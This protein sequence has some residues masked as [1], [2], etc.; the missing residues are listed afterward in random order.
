MKKI[1]V[2]T[3]I[4]GN[5]PFDGLKDLDESYLTDA[6]FYCFTNLDINSDKWKIVNV[7]L[8]P[9]ENPRLLARQY[10]TRPH[11]TLP[12]YKYHFWV[13]GSIQLLESPKKIVEDYMKGY[14]VT[15]LLHPDRTCAYDEGWV[16][17]AWGLDDHNKIDGLLG[18]MNYDGYPVKNGLCETGVVIR[19]NNEHVR[20][21]NEFWWEMIST[22]SLRDQISFNYCLWKYAIKHNL[23]DG[24]TNIQA[25][26]PPNST[27][28]KII[29]LH[30]HG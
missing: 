9:D 21:F 14:E 8:R 23:F 19:E 15:A 10:K 18:K 3:A 22:Y 29:K 12:D 5:K 30:N 25:N 24:L 4:F 16:C 2:Y 28:I 13:D 17:K 27:Q 6:D 7:P 26:S 11:I 20:K 1:A